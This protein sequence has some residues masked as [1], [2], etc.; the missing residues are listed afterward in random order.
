[1]A[2]GMARRTELLL[3]ERTGSVV[4]EGSAE[5]YLFVIYAC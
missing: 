4:V 3:F 1:M 2:G 5:S